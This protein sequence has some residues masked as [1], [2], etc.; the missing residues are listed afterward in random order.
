MMNTIIFEVTSQRHGRIR[1]GFVMQGTTLHAWCKS[2]AV[3][4]QGAYKAPCGQWVGPKAE[5]LVERISRAAGV[6]AR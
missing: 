5:G 6:D 2:N 4:R 3:L 1:A